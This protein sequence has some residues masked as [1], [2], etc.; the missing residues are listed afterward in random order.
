MFPIKIDSKGFLDMVSDH[1][2]LRILILKQMFQ[3]LQIA[4]AQV[5]ADYTS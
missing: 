1:S 3:R 2:N 5:K 4:L